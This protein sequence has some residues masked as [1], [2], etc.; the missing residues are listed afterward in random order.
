MLLLH[1]ERKRKREG[2]ALLALEQHGLA[3]ASGHAGGRTHAR[4]APHA[5]LLPTWQP[6]KTQPGNRR[7][8]PYSPERHQRVFIWHMGA[9]KDPFATNPQAAA[10]RTLPP[11]VSSDGVHCA[12]EA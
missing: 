10:T 5:R 1:I 6:A 7:A 2:L 11:N 8:N 4:T 12:R 3:G 9:P